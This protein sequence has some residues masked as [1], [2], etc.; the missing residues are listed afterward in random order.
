M[1]KF[2]LSY[3]NSS[4]PVGV[5]G[6]YARRVVVRIYGACFRGDLRRFNNKSPEHA[7]DRVFRGRYTATFRPDKW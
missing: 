3:Q 6:V 5:H 4:L 2:L 1:S 7:S